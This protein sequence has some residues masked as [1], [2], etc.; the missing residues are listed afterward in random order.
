[1]VFGRIK[2]TDMSDS[3]FGFE[4]KP[5]PNLLAS[6]RV[7]GVGC[8][9]YGVVDSLERCA[10]KHP[11]TCI[12]SASK[13]IGSISGTGALIPQLDGVFQIFIL[14]G[15]VAMGDAYRDMMPGGGFQDQGAEAVLMH[16]DDSVFRVR[17]KESVQGR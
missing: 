14:I 4:A 10:A 15:T 1:M 2:P 7:I 17:I 8:D 9:V 12:L 6:G 11:S 3:Q 5:P 16:M 13:Q